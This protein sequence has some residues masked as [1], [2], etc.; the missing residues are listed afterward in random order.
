VS[1]LARTPPPA[2]SITPTPPSARAATVRQSCAA[3]VALPLRPS[4]ARPVFCRSHRTYAPPLPSLAPHLRPSPSAPSPNPAHTLASST[5]F[6]Q[7][8][9]C[10][11]FSPSAHYVLCNLGLE[12]SGKLKSF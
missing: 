1:N 9:I 7:S 11:D 3:A 12:L 6:P 2:S 8:R 5:P 10:S 4:A